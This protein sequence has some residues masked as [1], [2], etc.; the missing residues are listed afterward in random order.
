MRPLVVDANILISA[1]LGTK[2]FERM[3]VATWT[4]AN[5]VHYLNGID[6]SQMLPD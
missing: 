4:S 6:F 1:V 3:K 5:V 2:V